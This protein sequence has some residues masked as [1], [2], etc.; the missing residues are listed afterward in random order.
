MAL[1]A[2][3]NKIHEVHVSGQASCEK[4]EEGTQEESAELAE[5]GDVAPATKWRCV[6][7]TMAIEITTEKCLRR[8]V[9]GL[10]LRGEEMK[11]RLNLRECG[12]C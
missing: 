3:K 9:I 11:G 8:S 7:G 4:W 1:P 5:R 6:D 2:Q 10:N 12:F